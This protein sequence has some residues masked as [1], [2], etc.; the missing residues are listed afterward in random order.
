M[1]RTVPHR[2]GQILAMVVIALLLTSCA[3]VSPLHK[4]ASVGDVAR[5]EEYIATGEPVNAKD[6]EGNTPLHC[7]YYHGHQAAVDRLIAYGADLTIRNRDGDT[8]LDMAH[9]AEAAKLIAAGAEVLDREGDWTDLTEGRRIYDELKGKDSTIVTKALVRQVLES[10]R[11]LQVLFLA[12]KLG[13]PGSED[14][15]NDVLEAYGDKSMAED[16]L[17]SGS[18]EL[19][20]GAQRWAN[21]RGYYIATGM[22]SHRVGWGRF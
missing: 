8:P 6:A 10:N 20:A 18:S 4:A 5:I 17:N 7:A 12:V 13:I 2:W 1:R 19:Y 21:K 16:Y 3:R 11:R 14:R 15:L 22:G 9:I